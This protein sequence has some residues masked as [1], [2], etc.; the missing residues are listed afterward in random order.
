MTLLPLLP[1]HYLKIY[2][3]NNSKVS[4]K[5][6]GYMAHSIKTWE[7]AKKA[8]EKEQEGLA[9]FACGA[10]VINTQDPFEMRKMR[11][12][13]EQCLPPLVLSEQMKEFAMAP[14]PPPAVPI[15]FPRGLFSP[16]TSPGSPF[17]FGGSPFRFPRGSQD[18]VRNTTVRR[19]IV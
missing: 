8:V 6:A 15:P 19:H 16:A 11:H 3:V 14:T 2:D 1:N 9:I 7:Q 18:W 13:L 5:Y 4:Q 17:R 10:G 12:E